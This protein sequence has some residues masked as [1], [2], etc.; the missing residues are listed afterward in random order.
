MLVVPNFSIRSAGALSFLNK[1]CRGHQGF[2]GSVH[3]HE[4]RFVDGEL[5]ELG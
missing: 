2:G 4:P 5:L 3:L 1:I